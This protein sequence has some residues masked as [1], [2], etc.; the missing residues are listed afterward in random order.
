MTDQIRVAVLFGGASSEHEV[1]RR[2]AYAIMSHLDPNKY[3]QIRIGITKNGEWLLYTGDPARIPGGEWEHDPANRP[4]L[5]SPSTAQ[6]GLLL[7]DTGECLPVDVVFPVLHGKNGEDGTIQGLLDLARIPYVGCGT[8]AS[9]TCMDKAAANMLL[10]QNGI[11][12]AKFVWCYAS[13]YAEDPAPI[14]A[15]IAAELGYPVFVKPANAGSSVGVTKVHDAAK[16]PEA[17]RIA[18]HEDGRIVIEEAI[19]GHEVECAVLGNDHPVASVV[20]EILPA[21]EFYTYDAKYQDANSRLAIPAPLPAET[22]ETI[23]RTAVQAYRM[24]GCTGLARVDFF[25]RHSDGA[26]L[27]NELNTLPGFT[28]I[29]MYPKL[30]DAAG[31]PFGPLLDRLIA[32]A[33]ERARG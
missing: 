25:V 14:E 33:Q 4:C 18:A 12:E 16:L 17:M 24:L 6:R 26:V 23:R 9:A 7:P 32:L 30:F 13:D 11:P 5:I 1:S 15:R 22:T 28:S 21:V 31:V 3:E 2:S 8:L 10:A 19:D 29:S 20:G 27:L